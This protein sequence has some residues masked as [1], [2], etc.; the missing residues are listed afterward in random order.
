MI[1]EYIFDIQ[2]STSFDLYDSWNNYHI[3][4]VAPRISRMWSAFFCFQFYQNI[5]NKVQIS[6]LLNKT[7]IVEI[8]LKFFL[9]SGNIESTKKADHILEMPGL[10][11]LSGYYLTTFTF[12]LRLVNKCSKLYKK[13]KKTFKSSSYCHVSWD[14]LYIIKISENGEWSANS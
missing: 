4:I 1:F 6:I 7:K 5:R 2:S 11:E 13:I 12:K 14:T 10:G 8:R 9:L 3:I